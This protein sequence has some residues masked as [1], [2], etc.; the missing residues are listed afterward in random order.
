MKYYIKRKNKAQG[1]FSKE[2]LR[3]RILKPSALVHD[4]QS[5]TWIRADQCPDLEDVI[6]PCPNTWWLASVMTLF[7]CL[8]FGIVGLLRAYQIHDLYRLG[9][10][11]EARVLSQETGRWI[12]IGIACGLILY[13]IILAFHGA[14][15]IKTLFTEHEIL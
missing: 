9:K 12:K 2:E 10:L 4:E 6:T 13:L 15:I 14:A 11:T 1:P 7:I 5:E 8:P 3:K